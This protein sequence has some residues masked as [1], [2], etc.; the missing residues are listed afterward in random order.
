LDETKHDDF[1]RYEIG[2]NNKRLYRI[3]VDMAYAKS[4]LAETGLPGLEVSIGMTIGHLPTQQSN[5]R[6][7]DHYNL[8]KDIILN[9]RERLFASFEKEV[10]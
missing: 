2:V 9:N 8:T 3:K 10:A 1:I 5:N 4:H 7:S 6:L